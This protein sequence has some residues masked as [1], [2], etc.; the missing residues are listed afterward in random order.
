MQDREYTPPRAR[1][2]TH[3]HAVLPFH[4]ILLTAN[5]RLDVIWRQDALESRIEGK[6]TGLDGFYRLR[7]GGEFEIQLSRL[8][9]SRSMNKHEQASTSI[10]KHTTGSKH[11]TPSVFGIWG[12]RVGETIFG[13]KFPVFFRRCTSD[14]LP[15]QCLSKRVRDHCPGRYLSDMLI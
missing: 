10:N 14:P 5:D 11:E 1:A 9:L 12:E 8:I 6:S 3:T 2:H 4:A 7:G 13:R 15:F